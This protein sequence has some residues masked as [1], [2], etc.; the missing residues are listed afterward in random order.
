MQ[1]VNSSIRQLG[2]CLLAY[3][4]EQD[5]ERFRAVVGEIDP[6]AL[7]ERSFWWQEAENLGAG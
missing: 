3:L 7:A 2:D 6:A 1:F 4:G 5:A